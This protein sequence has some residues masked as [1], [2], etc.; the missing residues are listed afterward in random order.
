MYL[1][2]TD[3]LIWVLRGHEAARS[4][5]REA[6]RESGPLSTSVVTVAELLGGMRSGE[7][8]T[9]WRLLDT[10]RKVHVD[11]RAAVEAGS[12]RRRF[13]ASHPGVQTADYLIAGS[14]VATGLSPATL[15]VKH[16]P[17]FPG[18]RPPFSLH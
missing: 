8:S 13:R 17:M 18:L 15:N 4:W 14:C 5:M 6:R 9:T 2:D 7:R 11:E 3:V 16:F 1:V 10:M 12:L